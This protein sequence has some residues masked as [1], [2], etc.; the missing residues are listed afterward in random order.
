M[1]GG[2]QQM[3]AYQVGIQMK[4]DILNNYS[5][6]A[7]RESH[8]LPIQFAKDHILKIEEDMKKMHERHVKLMREMDQNYRLIEQET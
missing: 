7:S 5:S 4:G 2:G 6:K 1:D 3:G 8:L